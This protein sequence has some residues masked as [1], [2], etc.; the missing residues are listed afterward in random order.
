MARKGGGVGDQEDS[1]WLLQGGVAGVAEWFVLQTRFSSSLEATTRSKRILTPPPG[2]WYCV[3][4]K[5]KQPVPEKVQGEAVRSEDSHLSVQARRWRELPQRGLRMSRIFWITDPNSR[6]QG[7]FESRSGRLSHIRKVLPDDGLESW[8]EN[9]G[10]ERSYGKLEF[11][12][13]VQ[14]KQI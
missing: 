10:D 9:L 11:L 4:R 8:D 2:Q 1:R 13:G 12:G 5:K 7:H 6:G 3:V 14:G